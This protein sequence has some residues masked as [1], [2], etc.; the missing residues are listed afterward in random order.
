M[1]EPVSREQ[2][3]FVAAAA[4][5]ASGR[6][7]AVLLQAMVDAETTAQMIRVLSM[8]SIPG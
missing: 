8:G 1:R 4:A 7:W 2:G 6:G 5:L 3:R